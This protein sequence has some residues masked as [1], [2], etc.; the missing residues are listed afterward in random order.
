M[1]LAEE[2]EVQQQTAEGMMPYTGLITAYLQSKNFI[3]SG[4]SLFSLD[5]SENSQHLLLP[6]KKVEGV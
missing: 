3:A 1:N 5:S 2:G 6:V 4:S